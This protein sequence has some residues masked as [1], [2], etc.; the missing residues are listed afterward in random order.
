ML[1]AMTRAALAPGLLLALTAACTPAPPPSIPLLDAGPVIDV[2]RDAPVIDVPVTDGEPADGPPADARP[3]AMD[4]PSCDMRADCDT[5]AGCETALGTITNCMGCADR[6]MAP[7]GAVATC[8]FATGCDFDCNLGFENCDAI[9]GNG[10]EINTNTDRQHC[11][12]CTTTCPIYGLNTRAVCVG[13]DC[14]LPCNMNF[15]DC[16]GDLADPTGNGCEIDTANSLMHCGG[17]D[18]PCSLPVTALNANPRCSSGSCQMV[19]DTGFRDC[20]ANQLDGCEI[21]GSACP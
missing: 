3:D 19:C 11:G 4:A 12:D 20:N 1:S 5:T 21:M 10:C 14:T 9:P 18:A 16:D 2:G 17:C 15:A 6:C 8:D 7:A 13:G